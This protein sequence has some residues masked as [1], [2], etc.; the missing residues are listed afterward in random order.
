MP[1]MHKIV[2]LLLLLKQIGAAEGLRLLLEALEVV[3]VT[4]VVVVRCGV[5]GASRLG[6]HDCCVC[7]CFEGEVAVLGSN[8]FT[9]AEES[10]LAKASE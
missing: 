6:G 2:L 10:E 3:A 5:V 4:A 7:D 8:V 1:V 9:S